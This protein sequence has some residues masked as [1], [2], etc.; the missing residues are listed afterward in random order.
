MPECDRREFFT[1]AAIFAA[2]ATAAMLNQKE[3]EAG[4]P[5]FMNNVPDPVA[6]GD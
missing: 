1:G 2:A 4:N 5:S 3:S 6:S